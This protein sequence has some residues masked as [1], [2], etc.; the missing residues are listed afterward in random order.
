[1]KAP[2]DLERLLHM[3]DAGL[4]ALR[5]AEGEGRES[6]EKD[7]KLVFA[8]VRA[9]EIIGEA[10]ANVT[11]PTRDQYAHIPWALIVGMCNRLIHG[12][13]DVDIDQVWK[14]VIEDL[15]PLIAELEKIIQPDMSK[16]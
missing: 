12:Y 9:A 7:E 5:F 4:A 6:L 11:K 10:A 15:P 2:D 14:T 16:S 13:F 3:R 1:M 8:L